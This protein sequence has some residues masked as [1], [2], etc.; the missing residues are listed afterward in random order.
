M[1]TSGSAPL[2]PDLPL[3]DPAG[4]RLGY[5]RFSRLIA[6]AI[7]S[8]APVEGLVLGL[9]GPRGAGRTTVA[10]FVRR[11]IVDV[12]HTV[13]TEFN[14]WRYAAGDDISRRYLDVLVPVLA[15]GVEAGRDPAAVRAAAAEVLRRERTRHVI[16]VDDLDRVAPERAAEIGRLVSAVTDLPNVVHLLILERT[17]LPEGDLERVVQVPFDLPL[18]EGLAQMLFEDLRALMAANPHSSA[19]T[20]EHWDQ[21]FS[22]GIESL[23]E[24]PRD[25]VRLMNV[26][27]LT[28]PP[29]CRELNPVD[30]IAV[31]AMRV[32]LPGLY[33]T[34]RRHPNAFAGEPRTVAVAGTAPESREFHD[35]W[36]AELPDRVREAAQTLVLRLFPTVPDFPGA[37]VSRDM[38]GNTRQ[39]LHVASPELFEAYFQFV[40]PETTVSNAEMDA[41]MAHLDDR[42]A[43]AALLLRLASERDSS[44]APRVTG[45]LDR[46]RDSVTTLD[47]EHAANAVGGLLA[48]GDDLPDRQGAVG[49]VVALLRQIPSGARRELVY[50]G[51]VSG[52]IVTAAA[53]TV[54]LGQEHGRH[55]ADP[56]EPEDARLVSAVELEQLEQAVLS[57]IRQ[58]AESGRFASSPDL[59]ALLA[60]WRAWDADG[61][62]RWVASAIQRDDVL[63]QIVGAFVMRVRADGGPARGPHGSLRLDPEALRPYV[64]PEVIV[65]RVRRLARD[66]SLGSEVTTALD[67]F[68][69]EY[70]LRRENAVQ[71][72]DE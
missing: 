23:I 41:H 19:V 33:D 66:N 45:F 8:M 30:F 50:R 46:L 61:C 9:H 63:A 57:R 25:I 48:A 67:Q 40:V 16:V 70:E 47:A 12:P 27:R 10:N 55:G 54:A 38:S 65:D 58:Y 64:A 1:P 35:A 44:G 5:V 37:V 32:F 13:V 2:S 39:E 29:V 17:T 34:I 14:P 56:I 15:P 42:A 43:F 6:N 49:L 3:E 60:A 36:A 28:Y 4:D 24:T 71:Q 59:P 69:L 52:G 7:A 53:V 31:E 21:I 62:P 11:H 20:D 22:P 68:V 51:G 26:L 18:P 72:N